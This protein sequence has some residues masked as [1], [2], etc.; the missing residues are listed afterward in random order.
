MQFKCERKFP[1]QGVT[2]TL[3]TAMEVTP[4]NTHQL[5]ASIIQQLGFYIYRN[6]PAQRPF[7]IHPFQNKMCRAA[8][9][10][11]SLHA[12]QS[13]NRKEQGVE[14]ACWHATEFFSLCSH[15]G[16][17]N[18]HTWRATMLLESD[19]VK[20]FLLFLKYFLRCTSRDSKFGSVKRNL[21]P[22]LVQWGRD[23]GVCD[24]KVNRPKHALVRAKEEHMQTQVFCCAQIDLIR[25]NV[26][27][28]ALCS[29]FSYFFIGKGKRADWTAWQKTCLLQCHSSVC[30]ETVMSTSFNFAA[31][32]L[33]SFIV[34]NLLYVFLLPIQSL[35][36]TKPIQMKDA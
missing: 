33:N 6:T 25:K 32:K 30:L 14:T 1:S 34:L 13:A 4:H 16:E 20:G 9:I 36:K 29:A 18:A 31:R 15:S 12:Q 11:S 23:K 5:I 19:I 35:I 17:G 22:R 24:A 26:H 2:S 27:A 28:E 21:H 8:S 3:I 10:F 7:L